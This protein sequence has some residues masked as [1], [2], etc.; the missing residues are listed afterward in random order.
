MAGASTAAAPVFARALTAEAAPAGPQPKGAR[1]PL[2]L[3]V[4]VN[5]RQRRVSL[6]VRTTLL[7]ALREHL[8]L[9]G[10]KK[11]CDHNAVPVPYG[12]TGDAFCRA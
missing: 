6:D 7:D 2:D 5:G 8:G 12:W 11:G 3:T 10:T 4:A 9:P 1:E